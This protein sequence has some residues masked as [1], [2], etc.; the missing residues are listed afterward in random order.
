MSGTPLNQFGAGAIWGQ[1]FLVPRGSVGRTRAVWD[2]NLRLAYHVPVLAATDARL[3]VD[4]LHLGNPR[5]TVRRDQTLYFAMNEAGDQINR[6]SDY[7]KATAF[8]PPTAVRIG[9]EI[10]R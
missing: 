8:Q 5:G 9:F 6:N 10:G 2:L 4:V 7:L 3:V 1:R